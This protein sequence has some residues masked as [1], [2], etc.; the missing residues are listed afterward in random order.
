MRETLSNFAKLVKYDDGCSL[1]ELI[2]AV[3]ILNR[4]TFTQE[5]IE[6]LCDKLEQY[7]HFKIPFV[8]MLQLINNMIINAI[9]A[10]EHTS[11][12]KIRLQTTLDENTLTLSIFDNGAKIPIDI[13][14]K[15]FDYG[16]SASGGS[17]IGLFHARYLCQMYD[18]SIYYHE[19]DDMKGFMITLP[20][21]KDNL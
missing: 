6:F 20:I 1:S 2:D 15:I 19:I 7:I 18:G 13:Q 12:K 10:V 4:A 16:F 14:S 8:S 3:K 9:K 17:G 5:K 11:N 21:L